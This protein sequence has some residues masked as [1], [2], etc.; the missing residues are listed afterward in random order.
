[1]Q[2]AMRQLMTMRQ[3]PKE[4]LDGFTK[5]FLSQQEV[6]EDVWGKLIPQMMKGK[7]TEEQEKARHKF[8]ACVFLAGVDG[9][10]Y[11]KTMDDLNNNFLLGAVSYP[12]DVPSMLSLLTNWRGDGG[13]NRYVNDLRDGVMGASFVQEEGRPEGRSLKRCYCCG[14]RG[15][16]A[17]TCPNQG[18]RNKAEK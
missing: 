4:S 16:S 9:K 6:T 1:M 13:G 17:A 3:D 7:A 2:A 10:Q 18:T 11:G 8:L 14:K 5:R 12:T 15:H